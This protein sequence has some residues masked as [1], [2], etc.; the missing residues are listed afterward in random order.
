MSEKR[1]FGKN[2]EDPW[3]ALAKGPREVMASIWQDY[4]TAVLGVS[5]TSGRFKILRRE[6]DKAAGFDTIFENWNTLAPESRA[7]AWQRLVTASRDK[8]KALGEACVRCG[9]CCEKSSPT[10]LT[11]DLPLFQQEVLTWNDVY[12]LRA[13]EPVTSREGR[14]TALE[15]ERLKIREVPGSSQCWFY[16]AA[17]QSCR[18]YENRPEQCRR[19]NCWEEPPRPPAAA[20]L[21]SRRDLLAAV[22][23]VWDLIG[24]H[25]ERCG[26][27]KVV[28][29]LKA[30][31]AGQE[32]AT[33]PLFDALHFD[34]YLRK[35]LLDDWGLTEAATEFLLG[36]PLPEFLKAHGLKATLTPEGVFRL[37]LKEEPA[38]SA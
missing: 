31:A 12:T 32:E 17:T 13:G 27:D 10:L 20:Q 38:A 25:Q 2:H 11:H 14:P 3:E 35:M 21:L 4:L 22:P 18:I 9:E 8:L 16:L 36:R 30:L 6:I 1:F 29:A 19:Q 37:E 15:A 34:H 23:E 5:A 28:Q 26:Y 24:T 33:E 7:A